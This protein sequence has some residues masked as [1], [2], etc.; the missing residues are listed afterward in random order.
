MG[1]ANEEFV[2]GG[3]GD[4]DQAEASQALETGFPGFFE[5]GFADGDALRRQA[6][7]TGARWPSPR[8]APPAL[9]SHEPTT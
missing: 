2:R 4:R 1:A 8:P 9:T 6:P 5:G 7:A 3:P